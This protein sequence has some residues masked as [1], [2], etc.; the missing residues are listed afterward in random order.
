MQ[1]LREE[2][3]GVARRRNLR[4]AEAQARSPCASYELPIVLSNGLDP[5]WARSVPKSSLFP[6]F[7]SSL[8]TVCIQS[9]ALAYSTLTVC[10]QLA[11]LAYSALTVCLQLGATP[12][13]LLTTWVTSS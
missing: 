3:G 1:D 7:A 10:L 5:G 12:C 13:S 6:Q 2:E 11:A 9:G 8:L 4:P